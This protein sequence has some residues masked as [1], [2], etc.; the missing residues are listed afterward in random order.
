VRKHCQN[1]VEVAVSTRVVGGRVSPGYGPG[2]DLVDAGAVMV[3][4]LPPSQARVLLMAA[5]SAGLPLR[6]VVDRVL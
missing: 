3:S 2:R 6:D 1:G 4:G 5:L